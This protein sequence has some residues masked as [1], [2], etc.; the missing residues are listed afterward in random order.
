MVKMNFKSDKVNFDYSEE[1][2][3][4]EINP[5]KIKQFIAM[6]GGFIGAVYLAL[7]ASGIY[8]DWLNP[9]KLDAWMN[10]LNTGIP[11]VF[12]LY[13]I[14]KN[15]FI[16]TSRSRDQETFLKQSGKK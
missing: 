9:Q 16:L 6:I 13:G 11:I 7:S 3:R 8:I 1:D 5:D 2:N 4:I 15:T 10:V 12:V 14:W